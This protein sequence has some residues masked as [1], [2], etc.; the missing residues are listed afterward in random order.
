MTKG[1]EEKQKCTIQYAMCAFGLRVQVLHFTFSTFFLFFFFV[2]AF[3]D[4][5]RQI[6]LL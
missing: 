4:F 1:M 2:P 5:G 6:L 3:A